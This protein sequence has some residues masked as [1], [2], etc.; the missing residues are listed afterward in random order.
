MPHYVSTVIAR[1]KDPA[2]YY[3]SLLLVDT[4]KPT[5]PFWFGVKDRVGFS[6]LL[7]GSDNWLYQLTERFTRIVYGASAQPVP[8]V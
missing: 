1:L 4:E 2:I 7:Y 8:K 5:G 3:Y 6:N